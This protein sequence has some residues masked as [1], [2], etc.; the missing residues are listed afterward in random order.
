MLSFI[1]KSKSFIDPLAKTVGS[2]LLASILLSSSLTAIAAENNGI[3]DTIIRVGSTLSL[4]SDVSKVASDLKLGLEAALK[5]EKVQG[6]AVQLLVEDDQYIPDKAVAGAKKLIDQGIFV[7]LGSNGTA[8]TIAVLPVL[9]EHKIPAVGFQWGAQPAPGDV[10]TFR[11][12]Y[13]QEVATAIETALSAG[14]KPQEICFYAQNDAFGMNGIK[15]ATEVLSKQPGMETVVEKLKQI[16]AMPEPGP[17]RNN[18]GPLGVYERGAIHAGLGYESLKKWEKANNT[19]CRF[20]TTASTALPAVNAIAF[21]NTYKGESWAYSVMTT[22]G[23]EV[24]SNGLDKQATKA[25]IVATQVVPMLDP[26]FPIT[27]EARK[28]LGDSLTPF[29]MEGFV[30]AKMFL[31]IMRNIKGD[32]TRENF[33]KSARSQVFDIGGLKIDFTSGSYQ[34]GSSTVFLSYLEGNAFKAITA[35]QLAKELTK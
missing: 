9:A 33:V 6:R 12:N 11:P 3:T 5:G 21:M 22:A 1:D 32:L 20:I 29:A 10:F 7:M 34:P 16:M 24:L 31:A 25:R 19:K 8:N 35:Q 13:A 26:A 17:K 18:I 27:I 2:A 14:V 28:A 4:N 23:G 30:V 15:G